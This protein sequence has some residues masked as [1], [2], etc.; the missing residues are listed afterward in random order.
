M[1]TEAVVWWQA[2]RSQCALALSRL[3]DA[4]LKNQNALTSLVDHDEQSPAAER[5]LRVRL[6]KSVN[7]AVG[8]FHKSDLNGRSMSPLPSKRAKPVSIRAVHAMFG[9]SSPFPSSFPFAPSVPFGES[10]CKLLDTQRGICLL[11]RR[12]QQR[13][14]T[15]IWQA[16]CGSYSK[17]KG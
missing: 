16:L 14:T 1:A 5:E 2:P 9:P 3:T 8:C 17:C 6:N 11:R 15:C 13:L 10:H 4:E 7:Q 12:E